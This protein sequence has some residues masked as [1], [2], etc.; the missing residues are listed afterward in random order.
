LARLRAAI[1]A[2]GD[3]VYEWDLTSNRIT[4]S[5][6][7]MQLFAASETGP[8][9]NGD[10]YKTRV[11]PEDLPRRNA[12]LSDHLS[13][14][15]AYDCEYRVRDDRGDYQW[16]HD[17]GAIERSRGGRPMRLV[18]ALRL[19]T[20][21]KRQE[22]RL[23]YLANFDDLT[24]HFNKL[25][26]RE[27]LDH[28]LV[29]SLRY[30][31]PGAFLVV[32]IDQLGM[33][34]TAY[35]SEAGDTV[36]VETSQ[37][38]ERC[39]RAI[40]IV[41][42]L[43]GDRFGVVLTGC[44]EKEMISAAER[45]L[46]IIRHEAVVTRASPLHVTASIGAVVFPAHAQ[47]SF[48][49]MIKAESALLD[50]KMAGRDC[51]RVYELSEEQR[52]CCRANLDIGEEVKLALKEHRL[53]FAYQPVVD[54][55]TR[56]TRYNECL[57][58]MRATDGKL[59]PAGQFIPV[60]EQLGLIRAIDRH[61]LDLAMLDLIQY[62]DVSLA[63]NISGLTSAERSW[64]RAL[65]AHLKG[66]PEIACRLIIEITETAAVHDFEDSARFV[67]ALRELGCS[68]ALDDFGA[69]FTSF[70]HLKS[71]PVDVLKIDGSFVDGVDRNP[72]S[73]L[74]IRNLL[75]LARAFNLAT[76]A[77][78]VERPEEAAF[79]TN[80]GVDYLQGYYFGKPAVNPD[81]RAEA[82]AG[83]ASVLG[84]DPP[85]AEAAK[86]RAVS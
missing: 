54:T 49:V 2:S 80:E 34:N 57:L 51:V 17:R 32:G 81:W 37:R 24:G 4:W 30:R 12:A 9:T 65:V 58:R 73:Q 85:M 33:I 26:L 47:T 6:E 35:G 29:R 63:L 23:Q 15:G 76:V 62:T 40:D 43:A 19:V 44:D 56:E 5:G 20:R 38:L 16:V 50:A 27:A 59:V 86:R 61:A 64:L 75:S 67:T 13:G 8:P 48:D 53:L 22:E 3:I 55:A 21:R 83:A 60:A 39:L 45:A 82:E 66:R 71:L 31:Q 42:R 69:G 28:A 36:L 11:S 14:S 41:G 25:R 84:S 52:R 1:R 7:T 74:F 72:Q 10:D 77:E 79:L 18:G 46:K 70:H 78:R 68:V